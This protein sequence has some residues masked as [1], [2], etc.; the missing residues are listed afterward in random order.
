MYILALI[1]RSKSMHFCLA[2]V[3]DGIYN[4]AKILKYPTKADAIVNPMPHTSA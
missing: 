4:V 2:N 3:Q 1:R